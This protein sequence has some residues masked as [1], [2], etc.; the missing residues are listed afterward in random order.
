VNNVATHRYCSDGGRLHP[1]V[2]ITNAW[3]NHNTDFGQPDSTP[4]GGFVLVYLLL[5]ESVCLMLRFF[6]FLEFHS[7]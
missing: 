7:R 4:R 6:A 2:P 3:L 1:S 5:Q